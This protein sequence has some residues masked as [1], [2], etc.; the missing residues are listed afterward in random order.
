MVTKQK[1]KNTMVITIA[2]EK[3]DSNQRR[4]KSS[5]LQSDAIAARRPSQVSC[6]S[7]L[8]RIDWKLVQAHELW[9]N[10]NNE[11]LTDL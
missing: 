7:Q 6:T 11:T 5:D 1:E 4:P 3:L 2:W 9:K 8:G 10:K